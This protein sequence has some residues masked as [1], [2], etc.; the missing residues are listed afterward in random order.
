VKAEFLV[1][2]CSYARVYSKL[3]DPEEKVRLDWLAKQRIF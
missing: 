1:A 3:G 2:I